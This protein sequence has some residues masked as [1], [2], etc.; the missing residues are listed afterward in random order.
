VVLVIGGQEHRLGR[1][2]RR[3]HPAQHQT[4]R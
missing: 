1:G 3:S 2:D 4:L